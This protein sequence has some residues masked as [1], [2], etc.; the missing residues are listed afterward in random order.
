MISICISLLR[1]EIELLPICQP[2]TFFFMLS[3]TLKLCVQSLGLPRCQAQESEPGVVVKMVS[4]LLT[5]TVRL[6]SVPC[7]PGCVWRLAL[8]WAGEEEETQVWCGE[9]TAGDKVKV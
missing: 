3:L 8:D 1:S 2:F 4:S 6:H 9:K 7:T 5:G